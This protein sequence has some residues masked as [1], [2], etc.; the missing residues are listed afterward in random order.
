MPRAHEAPLMIH[1]SAKF[2]NLVFCIVNY[3]S[4]PSLSLSSEKDGEM[5]FDA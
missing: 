3:F 4:R 2:R 5:A 1:K